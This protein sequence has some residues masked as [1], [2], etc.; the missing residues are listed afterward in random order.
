MLKTRRSLLASVLTTGLVI[1]TLAGCSAGNPN[2]SSAEDALEE[3]N[4]QRALSS[5]EQALEED[6]ANVEAYQLRA[7]IL[8]QM[9]DSTMPPEEYKQLYQQAREA[10]QQAV[11][12]DPSVRSDVEGRRQLAYFD[13]FQRG[14]KAFQRGQ[15][16]GDST[17]FREAAAFFGAA[18]AIYPDSADTHLNE[19]YARISMGEREEAIP[20]LETYVERADTVDENAYSILGRLYLTNNRVDDAITLLEEGS[21]VYPDNDEFQSLLLNAY[22]QSGDTEKAMSAYR[23]EVEEN[24]ENPTYRYNYGSM[25]LQANR[26]EE[27]I[28]QL[29]KA[30]ELDASQANIQYNLGAA[31]VNRAAAVN[32]SVAALQ[33]RL[34]EQDR[35]QASQEQ[36][37]RIKKLAQERT[38]AFRD[39]IPPLERARQLSGEGGEYYQDACRALFQAYVQTEQTEKA[40]DV[41]ECAGMEEGRADELRENQQ[42]GGGG[43]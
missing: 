35:Q 25:L 6:S 30:A 29:K 37:K 1:A 12:Y 22:Q 19:A 24:P 8:R 34:R 32:D 2:I 26:Y 40:S 18:G 27:A 7:Q 13:Q 42:E 43:N 15:Q 11:Q 14:A 23:Q 39:A 38:E 17:A 20:V 10:E 5:I 28:A 4:Y 33:K 3:N 31:Y 16:Q 9:A 21:E 41:E 36:A